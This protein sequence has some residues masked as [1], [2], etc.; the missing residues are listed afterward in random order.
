MPKL[1]FQQNF[2]KN[3][4]QRFKIELQVSKLA[5]SSEK[6][7]SFSANEGP[8][9]LR[10]WAQEWTD[11]IPV[12][13]SYCCPLAALLTQR[14]RKPWLTSKALVEK[15]SRM[16][17]HRHVL[18]GSLTSLFAN[19][20]LVFWR[21]GQRPWTVQTMMLLTTLFPSWHRLEIGSSSFCAASCNAVAEMPLDTSFHFFSQLKVNNTCQAS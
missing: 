15:K 14:F 8:S 21:R 18:I 10:I 6:P 16:Q 5:S 3:K 13:D 1:P 19:H 20:T 2:K 17:L 9:K 12:P 4:K 11:L 7:S